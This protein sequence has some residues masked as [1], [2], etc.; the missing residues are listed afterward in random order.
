MVVVQQE[1]LNQTANLLGGAAQLRAALDI[2]AEQH[3]EWFSW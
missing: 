1:G 3:I 2:S